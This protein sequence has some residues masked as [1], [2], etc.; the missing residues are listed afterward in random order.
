M[1]TAKTAK[2]GT[3]GT[4]RTISQY[5]QSLEPE[6][7]RALGELRERVGKGLPGARETMSYGMPTWEIAGEP[8]CAAASQKNYMALY[9]CEIPVLDRHREA[10]AHLDVGK[11]CIRFKQLDDL[12]IATLKK[13]FREAARGRGKPARG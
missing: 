12:P 10:F 2:K 5:M 13:M 1:A 8:V 7:R 9:F 4:G 11:S 3:E 6:R